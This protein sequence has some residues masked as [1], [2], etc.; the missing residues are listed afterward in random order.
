[1]TI[2]TIATVPCVDGEVTEPDEGEYVMD[3]TSSDGSV[4]CTLTNTPTLTGGRTNTV[5]VNGSSPA[6]RASTASAVVIRD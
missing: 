5:D 2:M 3:V 6:D 4:D 1:M